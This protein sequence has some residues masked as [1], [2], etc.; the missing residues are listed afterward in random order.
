MYLTGKGKSAS[1]AF[2][3]LGIDVA[4]MGDAETVRQ[5]ITNR[6]NATRLNPGLEQLIGKA[7]GDR[8]V[9]FAS[10][11]LASQFWKMRG[12]NGPGQNA[13]LL[14]AIEESSGGVKF[15]PNV[16]FSFDAVAKTD[17]DANSLADVVRFLASAAQVKKDQ[18]AN[19]GVI[20]PALD[21]LK[22]TTSGNELH[23]STSLPEDA[24]ETLVARIQAN[25]GRPRPIRN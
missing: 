9:W 16:N 8:D 21:N 3:F 7:S 25:H 10:V 19:P 13:R 18:D 6:T 22:L 12:P 14:Q 20:G 1:K 5:V 4:V 2:S 24:L 15:G 17:K 23:V 11:G